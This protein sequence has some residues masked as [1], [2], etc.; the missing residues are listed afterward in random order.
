MQKNKISSGF[1]VRMWDNFMKKA[2]AGTPVRDFTR[3]A[4]IVGP[5]AIDVSTGLLAGPTTPPEK[6]INE[7]FIEGTQ[8]TA[9]SN[10]YP[11]VYICP[12]SNLL[13]TDFCPTPVQ[14]F[15]SSQEEIPTQYCTIHNSPI[16]NPGN[17]QNNSGNQ[18]DLDPNQENENNTVEPNKPDNEI[19][20]HK[21]NKNNQTFDPP[22]ISENNSEG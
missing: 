16:T 1:P 22:N 2:L 21:N 15:Y 20:T 10:P 11:V 5:L 12:D 19:N 13:A 6:I 17:G 18:N 4:G 7:I 9:M 14:F 8:P 3:P